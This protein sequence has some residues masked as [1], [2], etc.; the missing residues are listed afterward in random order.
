MYCT[1]I[2]LG[3]NVHEHGIASTNG[4]EGPAS[5]IPGLSHCADGAPEEARPGRRVGIFETDS[6]YVKLAK[7][8]GQKGTFTIN[9]PIH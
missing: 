7:Q 9:T 4:I 6:D 1:F 5:Q 2:F 3:F 8:G